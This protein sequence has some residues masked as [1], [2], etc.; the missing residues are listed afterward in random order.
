MCVFHDDVCKINTNTCSCSSLV[1]L[2]SNQAARK[3]AEAKAATT[4][5]EGT[6]VG[7]GVAERKEVD[8]TDDGRE[9]E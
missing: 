8:A 1:K 3:D 7:A 6:T 9:K 4:P 5:M 2:A